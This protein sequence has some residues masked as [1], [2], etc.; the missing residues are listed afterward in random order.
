[1]AATVVARPSAAMASLQRRASEDTD[2]I[3][4]KKITKNGPA[5]TIRRLNVSDDSTLRESTRY[6]L[7][8]WRLPVSEVLSRGTHNSV[9]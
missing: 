6:S 4:R 7:P 5:M 8:A 9:S 1:M 2:G 3:L